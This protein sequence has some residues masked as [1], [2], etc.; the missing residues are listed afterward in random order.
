MADQM[1]TAPDPEA[2]LAQIRSLLDQYLALGSTTPVAPEAQALAQA[3]DQSSAQGPGVGEPGGYP[4]T[5]M[6]AAPEPGP[7]PPVDTSATGGSEDQ[8]LAEPPPNQGAK[9]YG[10]AN[11]TA[12]DRLKKRN[13]K[14]SKAKA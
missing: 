8:S 3:I 9:T 14:G 13:A 11:K 10:E 12:L 4:G 1:A 7:T 2:L 5:D 6:S